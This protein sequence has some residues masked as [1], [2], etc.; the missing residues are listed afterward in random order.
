MQPGAY[1]PRDTPGTVLS[2]LLRDH[3]DDFVE[4]VQEDGARCWPHA[5][6][7][8]PDG[9]FYETDAGALR[10]HGLGPPRDADIVTLVRRVTDRVARLLARWTSDS[11]A[12]VL[13][14]C[15]AMPPSEHVRRA[16]LNKPSPRAPRL[17]KPLC[18]RSPEGLEVHA[19]VHVRA[20]DRTGLERL[21]RYLMRP[22][23]PEDRLRRLED[24]RIELRLK[25]TWKGGVTALV[26]EPH[27]L[28][29]RLAALIPRPR[30][31][32]TR[33]FGVFASRHSWRAR[34]VP[35]PPAP[36]RT[37]V[38]T[39]PKRPARMRWPDLMQRVFRVDVLHCTAC[40]G[41]LRLIAAIFA[42][43]AVAAILAAIH[44]GPTAPAPYQQGRAIRGPPP[45][46]GTT[47]T[48]GGP[49]RS[50]REG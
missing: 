1:H 6:L 21:C 15:A 9:V 5:H 30:I 17:R 27:Q 39:A 42:P 40:G 37:G 46:A 47:R 10:F 50:L 44:A 25:R 20:A 18:A 16:P 19:A 48:R 14:Q 33:Y 26:F 32:M 4:R 45:D 7:L 12:R 22:A 28:I 23:I 13:L 34:V 31:P 3:L 43:T 8:A 24:G 29:A 38:P 49:S 36:A 35:Q 11:P 41:R 2:T